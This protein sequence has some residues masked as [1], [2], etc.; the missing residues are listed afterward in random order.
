MSPKFCPW[1][2][3]DKYNVCLSIWS[4]VKIWKKKLL[5]L[6]K[7]VALCAEKRPPLPMLKAASDTIFGL[8]NKTKKTKSNQNMV[9]FIA[10]NCSLAEEKATLFH[11]ESSSLVLWQRG[12]F[13]G[14][15]YVSPVSNNGNSE[16]RGKTKKY[17]CSLPYKL[18]Q[19]PQIS[20]KWNTLLKGY[21]TKQGWFDNL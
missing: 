16:A 8:L 6:L 7:S 18:S 15:M 19:N 3:N 14:L 5:L 17:F 9:A 2:K 11:A 20:L 12:P 13:I 10:K 1:R 4:K 21:I